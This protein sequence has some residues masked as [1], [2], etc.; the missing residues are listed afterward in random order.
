MAIKSD[1]KDRAN[2]IITKSRLY[3]IMVGTF[4]AGILAVAILYTYDH[5]GASTTKAEQ[6]SHVNSILW[7]LAVW[8]AGII[9]G[10]IIADGD[11]K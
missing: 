1:Y 8:N 7:L 2:P 6:I 9:M 5:M 11:E 10:L 3:R 4:L